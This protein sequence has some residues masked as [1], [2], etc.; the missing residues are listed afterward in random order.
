MRRVCY[1]RRKAENSF[2]EGVAA[3]LNATGKFHLFKLNT[4]RGR[5]ICQMMINYL[6]FPLVVVEGAIS[7]GCYQIGNL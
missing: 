1:I 3:T 5:W 2:T 6:F 7:G 4:T